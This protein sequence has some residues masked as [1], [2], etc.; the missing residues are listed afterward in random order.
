MHIVCNAEYENDAYMIINDLKDEYKIYLSFVLSRQDYFEG[1]EMH[2]EN[3]ENA[4]Y[5]ELYDKNY[6]GLHFGKELG[7]EADVIYYIDCLGDD[8]ECTSMIRGINLGITQM[9]LIDKRR[10]EDEMNFYATSLVIG[11]VDCL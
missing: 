8:F 10:F 1:K 3:V 11:N 6:S 9:A 7:I 2:V 5:I 4:E